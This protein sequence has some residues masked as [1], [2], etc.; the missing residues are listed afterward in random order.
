[1]QSIISKGKDINDAIDL[2]LEILDLTKK[3]VHIEIIESETKGF[4]GIGSK[5]AVVKLT[6]LEPHSSL[7]TKNKQISD[8]ILEPLITGILDENIERIPTNS[9]KNYIQDKDINKEFETDL[10]EG[11][12]WVKNGQLFCKSSPTHFAMVTVNKGIKLYK[13]NQLV[14][15]KTTIISEKD[16]YQI[17]VENEEKETKWTVSISKD[18][19]KVLLNVEPGYKI[20]RKVP[21][22]VANHHIE[23][24]V[25]ETKEIHNSL[26]YTD[27]MQKLEALR[28]TY[29]FNQDEIVNALKVKEHSTFEI[30][31]G[32]NPIHGK[33]GW[34]EVLVNADTQS[35][36]MEKEDGRVD[37]REV[38]TIPTVERGTIIA[39]VHPPIPGQL[40]YT[41]TND[42][43]PPKQT[44]PIVLE[45][46]IGIAVVEDKI[47]QPNL[48]DL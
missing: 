31:Y 19:L 29:G 28:V 5:P 14:K 38:K 48:D 37:F 30:A 33:D 41:G 22:I 15:E 43:I 20:I 23:L 36:L 35:G 2:G 21:N 26:N 40:G 11:K 27:V 17:K 47:A 12:V 8:D 6:K 32:Q 25:E 4:M 44:F 16:L 3:E 46:G 42:P 34:I 24:V 13:N 45:T 18:Q 10:L 7:L 9:T 39:V 1:M